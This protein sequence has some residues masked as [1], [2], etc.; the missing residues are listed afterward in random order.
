MIFFKISREHEKS[1]FLM[2]KTHDKSHLIWIFWSICDPTCSFTWCHY[3]FSGQIWYYELMQQS[4]HS[5]RLSVAPRNCWGQ[6]CY[7]LQ[8]TKSL[9]LKW[10]I[11]QEAFA[12]KYLAIIARMNATL[13][14]V[15]HW[16]TTFKFR[17]WK[18]YSL[19]R[20]FPNLLLV[21]CIQILY[22]W[23]LVM[24]TAHILYM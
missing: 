3:K 24:F 21:L 14:Y 15:Y 10:I 4:H 9:R 2:P 5:V 18:S 8:Q 11:V 17:M 1:V 16:L 19:D 6:K 20:R 12:M 13:M 7:S 22:V 23:C